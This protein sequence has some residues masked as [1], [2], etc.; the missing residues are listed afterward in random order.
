VSDKLY[1]LIQLDGYYDKP[2]RKDRNC[3]GGGV[4]VYVSTTLKVKRRVDLEYNNHEF[5][6]LQLDFSNKS[7]LICIVYRMNPFWRDFQHSIE[8][9]KLRNQIIKFHEIAFLVY[10]NQTLIRFMYHI[11]DF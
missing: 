10:P 2:F 4:L 7:V 3:F 11:W 5:I 9:S 6:W 1:R 8:Q